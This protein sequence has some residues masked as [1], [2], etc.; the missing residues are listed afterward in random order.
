MNIL[1]NRYY[2]NVIA[3][4]T[5]FF[6]E[7]GFKADGDIFKSDTKALKV[8]YNE[9]KQLY[10]LLAAD[11]EEGKVGEFSIITS[12]LFDDSQNAKDAA[13]VGIDFVDTARKAMGIKAKKKSVTGEADLPVAT[14]SAVNVSTLASKLLAHYP[15]LKETYRAE[16]SAK[17]KFLYLDF[18]T[19][20]FVPEIRA[21]LDGGNKKA[22]K[23][24]IDTLINVFV[25][26]D[27]AVSTLVVAVLAAA[28]GTNVDRFKAATAHMDECQPLITSVNQQIDLLIRNKKFAKAMNFKAE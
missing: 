2:D 13:A 25:T 16:T 27:K 12:Y 6:E 1:D 19:R 28:I 26:G 23:K 4:M 18:F 14:G 8:E 20:Y 24:L 7:N 9:T 17:G 21:T 22:T 15:N 5:P 3:E 10:N 11:L